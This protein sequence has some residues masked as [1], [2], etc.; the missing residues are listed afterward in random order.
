M[1]RQILAVWF[2]LLP[3]AASGQVMN[4]RITSGQIAI[5]NVCIM[6]VETR[7]TK[8]GW[9]SKETHPKEGDAW[10]TT[11]QPLIGESLATAGGKDVSQTIAPAILE[12]DENLR[13]TVFQL[14]QKLDSVVKLMGWH[15]FDIKRGRFSLGD[16][17]A[18]LPCAA[19]ADAI[20][21]LRASV[22]APLV[23]RFSQST[24]AMVFVDAKT[25][26]LL[27]YVKLNKMADLKKP[28]ESYMDSLV[29]RFR[30][31]Q[32]GH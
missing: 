28:R 1:T 27:A 20:L 4:A 26:E 22:N 6:P 17:V 13:Q 31:V 9:I 19:Q 7:W 29:D 3:G 11:L 18:R 15:T 12:H 32:E 14:Q 23:K 25:G 21:F 8:T 24:L 10:S 5:R 2:I 30:T 16:S